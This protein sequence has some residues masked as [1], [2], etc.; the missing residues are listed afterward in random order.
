MY[1]TVGL[2]IMFTNAHC[3]YKVVWMFNSGT[4]DE[5]HQYKDLLNIWQETNL[6]L[7]LSPHYPMHYEHLLIQYQ[8]LKHL[9]CKHFVNHII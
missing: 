3:A 5:I 8:Y 6:I 4:L 2:R 7:S 9:N 1:N